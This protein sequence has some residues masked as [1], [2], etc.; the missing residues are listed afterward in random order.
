MSAAKINL[1][2][3]IEEGT[4][5]F[6]AGTT[7]EVTA[8]KCTTNS[9]VCYAVQ[10]GTPVAVSVSPEAGKFTLHAASTTSAK[11]SWWIFG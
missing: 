1:A 9:N 11:V 5:S 8:A 6:S 7:V 4:H 3:V 2:E 10:G